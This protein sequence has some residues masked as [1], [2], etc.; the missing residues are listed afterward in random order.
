MKGSI[1]CAG[2]VA[3]V[4]ALAGC[5]GA[6]H[7]AVQSQTTPTSG[8]VQITASTVAPA[9]AGGDDAQLSSVQ[10]DLGGISDAA[11]QAD[12]DLDAAAAAQAQSDTP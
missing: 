10:A 8:A 9:P 2:V 12:T 7:L 3:S 11:S 5:T 6:G 4:L 1:A